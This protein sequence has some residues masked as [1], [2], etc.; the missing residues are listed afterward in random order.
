MIIAE[1][2]TSIFEKN[3]VRSFLLVILHFSIIQSVI[4]IF[5]TRLDCSNVE[6]KSFPFRFNGSSNYPIDSRF[7]YG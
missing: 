2:I 5:L 4:D 1:S 3:I 6:L 7:S